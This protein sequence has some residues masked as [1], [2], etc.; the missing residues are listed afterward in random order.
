MWFYLIFRYAGPESF[1]VSEEFR[2]DWG[3]YLVTNKNFIYAVIDGRGSGRRSSSML[4]S[5]YKNLG[6]F[7]IYDQINVTRLI[8][9]YYN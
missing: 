8:L 5:V 6:T 7:E 9:N 4:F 1:Q 2:V 3:T